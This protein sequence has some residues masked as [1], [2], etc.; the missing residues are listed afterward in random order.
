MKN[1]LTGTTRICGH[2]D[3]N[4]R[5]SRPDRPFCYEHDQAFQERFIDEC[6]N[7]SGVYKPAKY[8]VCRSC[9]AQRCQSSQRTQPSD[10]RQPQNDDRGWNRQDKETSPLAVKAVKL[11]RKNMKEYSKECENHESNTIQYLVEPV[12]RRPRLGC[13]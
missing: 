11:V 10:H 6:P 13:L 3:C 4:E 2:Q 7:C 5:T 1:S 8:C 9:Y 12:L